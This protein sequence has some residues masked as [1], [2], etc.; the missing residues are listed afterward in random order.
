[1]LTLTRCIDS[2]NTFVISVKHC[3]FISECVT[4]TVNNTGTVTIPSTKT[5][6]FQTPIPLDYI[7]FQLRARRDVRIGLSHIPGDQDP[8]YEIMIGGWGGTI[9]IIRRC[10]GVRRF[11]TWNDRK[12]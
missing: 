3:L 11:I 9:S 7:K 12:I 10:Q 1:M 6:Y 8:M 5:H 2:D 4:Y